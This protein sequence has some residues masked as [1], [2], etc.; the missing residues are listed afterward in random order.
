[1]RHETRC[2]THGLQGIGLACTHVAHA[3][4]TGEDVGFH[5][6]PPPED[7]ARPDAWCSS[8][9]ARHLDPSRDD[10]DS[11]FEEGDFKLLCAACWDVAKARLYDAALGG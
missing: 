5:W 2:R 10:P 8:C 6:G 1:M 7:T 3:I 4:D 9:E 11:W